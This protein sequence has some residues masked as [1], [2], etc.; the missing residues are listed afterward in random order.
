EARTI[1]VNT[2]VM[3]EIFYLFNSRYITDSIINWGGF[4]GNRYV[5]YAI[6]LLIIFQMGFTYLPQLQFLFGTAP[7][8]AGMWFL[9]VMVASSV[10]ILVEV[11]KL[12]YR[13]VSRNRQVHKR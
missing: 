12:I 13:M 3:F 4:V 8:S 1:A 9:I 11:E 10:L 7:I 2:P 5:L 6:G